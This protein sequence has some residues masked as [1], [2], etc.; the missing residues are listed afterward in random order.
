[1]SPTNVE[2]ISQRSTS[3]EPVPL[4][5]L[6]DV[7]VV[8]FDLDGTLHEDPRA[9]DFY[10]KALEEDMPD[11]TGFGLREEVAEVIQ[12]RHSAAEPGFFVD[13]NRGIVI[14]ARDWI[15]ERAVDWSGE[16]VVLPAGERADRI[17]HQGELRYLGDQW[18]II[19]ALAARRGATVQSLRSAFVKARL[20]VNDPETVLNRFAAL[21]EV[22]QRLSGGRRLLLA[23]NTSED[24]A[25]PLVQRLNMRPPFEVIRFDARK[26][27]GCAELIDH[28]N[29]RW[30]T[31]ASEVLV[32]GDNL[33]NDLLPPA[34]RG[35]RTI[36]ID[37]L[38]TDPTSRWSSARYEN[39][40]SFANALQEIPD[41]S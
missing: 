19:G 12:R 38:S 17:P 32:I 4:G 18:Q 35:C 41:G 3:G 24:L 14:E 16:T 36:H 33:W 39:F 15:A 10:A 5:N 7:K 26:P 8:L 23:T 30:N 9:T 22:L 27:A 21:D 25:R 20:F 29:Q 1:M 31:Q 40:A 28:A 13:P 34:G 6:A 2:T 37:P 11:G